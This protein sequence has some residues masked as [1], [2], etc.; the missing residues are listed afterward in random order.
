[1][2]K[3]NDWFNEKGYQQFEDW[4]AEGY[5][6]S[7]LAA[8]ANVHPETFRKWKRDNNLLADALA[9]GKARLLEKTKKALLKR[10]WGYDATESK[11]TE[12]KDAAG[13]VQSTT[14]TTTTKHIPS[15]TTA[16]IFMT[17]NLDRYHPILN[18]EGFL[19]DPASQFNKEM[20]MLLDAEYAS[21]GDFA[22][23]ANQ[24]A[25]APT[26]IDSEPW[27]EAEEAVEM[28]KIVIEFVNEC[29][30][31]AQKREFQKKI[32]ELKKAREDE[33]K[34]LP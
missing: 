7:S 25:T 24:L 19:S 28:V 17:K 3:K 27:R 34:L 20:K 2:T 6:E 13:E 23:T 33:G 16:L 22:G 10:T 15:D 12:V 4:T 8:L 30:S 1:M 26:Y 21:V 5:P 31:P 9:R 18:P 32:D 29:M 14:V 11:V